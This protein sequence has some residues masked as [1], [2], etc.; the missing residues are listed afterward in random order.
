MSISGLKNK[1]TFKKELG[2]FIRLAAKEKGI[3]I[4]Q[5][6]ERT[7]ISRPSLEHVVLGHNA[8]NAYTLYLLYWSL[9]LELEEFFWTVEAIDVVK[10]CPRC[11]GK[12]YLDD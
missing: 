8:P 7:G 4:V 3:T 1:E 2:K 5:L 11:M 6:A 10:Q 12:G 9:G